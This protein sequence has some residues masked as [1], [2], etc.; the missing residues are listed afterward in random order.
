MEIHLNYVEILS[1]CKLFWLVLIIQCK[2]TLNTKF[3]LT[4]F[5]KMFKI[6]YYIINYNNNAHNEIRVQK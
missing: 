4:N 3:T 1:L 6:H 5:T 2:V